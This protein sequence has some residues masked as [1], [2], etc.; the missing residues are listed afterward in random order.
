M[1]VLGLETSCDETAAAVVR[2]GREILSN[3]VVSQVDIH[4][5]YGGVV[6]ELASRKH[7][8]AISIVLDQA[9]RIADLGVADIEAVGVTRGPGLIG[10]LLVGIGAAKGLA[11]A[12]GVPICGV[13]HVHAH[14]FAPFLERADL[15]YPFVGLVV[16]GGH[17]ALYYVTGTFH[18]ELIG[19]TRDDAAGEAY[20]KVAK[21]LGLGYPGGAVIERRAANGK[22]GNLSFPRALSEPDQFDFSFSGVKSAVLRYVEHELG[23]SPHADSSGSFHPVSRSNPD[24]E[25]EATICSIAAAFQEAVVDVLVEKGIRAAQKFHV[26]TL[27]VAGGVAVNGALRARMADRGR[28]TGIETVFPN[29]ALCTDNAAMVAARADV[30]LRA[31]NVDSLDFSAISRW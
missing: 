2:N 15:E 8:E 9:L 17:T 5:E 29:P 13:N 27:I 10:S 24:T 30:L 23:L 22:P 6:P 25:F 14:L 16:S 28:R 18:L 20:D 7:I 3:V 19:K 26:D 31:G 11:W 4:R 1:I 12:L 21:L